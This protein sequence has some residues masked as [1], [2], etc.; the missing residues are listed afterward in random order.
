M[1][2]MQTTDGHA[3]PDGPAQ[4]GTP[5]TPQCPKYLL[6][7]ERSKLIY[8]VAG[9]RTDRERIHRATEEV[10]A[11]LVNALRGARAL[12]RSAQAGHARTAGVELIE[13]ELEAD[14]EIER[15]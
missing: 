4:C 13:I 2:D 10:D 12:A 5:S 11:Y 1:K 9:S 7:R 8:L 14:I 6:L 15:G 3:D